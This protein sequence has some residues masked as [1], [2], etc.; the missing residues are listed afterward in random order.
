MVFS[1]GHYCPHPAEIL[2]KRHHGCSTSF[3]RVLL[4]LFAMWQS[5]KRW[6]GSFV[7]WLH[8][9]GWFGIDFYKRL[10]SHWPGCYWGTWF[11]H[12][13]QA[14]SLFH[15]S[16]TSSTPN[17]ISLPR[18]PKHGRCH[19]CRWAVF[20]TG[21][22]LPWWHSWDLSTLLAPLIGAGGSKSRYHNE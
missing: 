5:S 7:S 18:S 16:Q 12:F 21:P 3:K 19:C 14:L 13:G 8:G 22:C 15:H 17:T 11:K 20:T 4:L 10:P 1:F 6:T 2:G 9:L